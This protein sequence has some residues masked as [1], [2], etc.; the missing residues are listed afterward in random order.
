[1]QLAYLFAVALDLCAEEKQISG[2]FLR[3]RRKLREKVCG[4]VII[5][6]HKQQILSRCKRDA[7]VSRCT[8]TAVFLMDGANLVGIFCGVVVADLPA[9]VGRAVF[10][11]KQLI[12]LTGLRQYGVEALRQ[13]RFDFINRDD[14]TEFRHG[15]FSLL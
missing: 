2:S 7:V 5:S 4:Q 14:Q 6:V 11:Q 13:V 12:I 1:M 3:R 9:A 8:G 15:A 10:N